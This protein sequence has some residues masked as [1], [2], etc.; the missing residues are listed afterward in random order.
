MDS[1]VEDKNLLKS[2]GVEGN[3]S[4]SPLKI[5]N[6]DQPSGCGNQKKKKNRRRFCFQ[7]T[8]FTN[9]A[10]YKKF[11]SFIEHQRKCA[12]VFRST[13]AALIKANKKLKQQVADSKKK[14]AADIEILK[15]I[16]LI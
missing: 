1:T 8:D 13:K 9:E 4:T 15:V 12:A 16:S 7:K 14:A 6:N 10:A 5:T 3:V 2:T 11:Q